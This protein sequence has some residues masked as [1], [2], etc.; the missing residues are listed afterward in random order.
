MKVIHLTRGLET[1]VD[2]EDFA[3]LSQHS[4]R[5]QG[6]KG[7]IY[8]ATAIKRRTVLLHRMLMPDV[9]EIDHKNGNKLDN[10]RC[11]LRSATPSQNSA[12][13]A[14][15]KI[16][17]ASGFRGV[18]KHFNKW[19]AYVQPGRYIFLGLFKTPQEAAKARD[20]AAI[21]Y[22]GEFA[23]LNFPQTTQQPHE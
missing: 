6:S 22:Y 2:D 17:S 4:W 23:T 21:K 16:R 19:V 8:A 13:R 11:N 5:A 18:R 20:E 1:I 15:D 9:K 14:N 10:R 7:R 3:L 12:N